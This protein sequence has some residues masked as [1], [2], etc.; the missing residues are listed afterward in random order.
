G[1]L[2][3]GPFGDAV[4]RRIAVLEVVRQW[5]KI[6]SLTDLCTVAGLAALDELGAARQRPVDRRVGEPEIQEPLARTRIIHADV[7]VDD[8]VA[9]R[10]AELEGDRAAGFAL[11]QDDEPAHVF[12]RDLLEKTLVEILEVGFGARARLLEQSLELG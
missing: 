6:V 12:G 5:I 9:N 8:N 3:H 1:H 2:R 4:E 7:L 11:A 10:E